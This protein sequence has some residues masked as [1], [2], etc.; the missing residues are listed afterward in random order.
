MANKPTRPRIKALPEPFRDGDGNAMHNA[1][2][3]DLT[4]KDCESVVSKLEFVQ[5]PV[6]TV[7]NEMAEPIKYG[8]FINSGLASILN[9][10]SDGKSVEVGLSG[11]KASWET[12]PSENCNRGELEDAACECYRHLNEQIKSWHK[13]SN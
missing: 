11:K 4:S 8:Y 13:D 6:H 5:L 1:I 7:L 12:R 3:A 2:L 10:M 9:V